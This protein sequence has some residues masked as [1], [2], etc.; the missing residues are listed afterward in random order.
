MM[1]PNNINDMY[2]LAPYLEALENYTV[3]EHHGM[4]EIII[5]YE[6]LHLNIRYDSLLFDKE[7]ELRILDVNKANVRYGYKRVIDYLNTELLI[8]K[9][10]KTINKLLDK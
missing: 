4:L 3:K 9:R 7:T 1:I 5:N 10:K 6:D 2:S 8:S